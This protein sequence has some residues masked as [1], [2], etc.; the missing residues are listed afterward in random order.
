MEFK[1]IVYQPGRVARII[2]NRP[3][4]LNAQSYQMLEE[5]N[6]A[7]FT[8]EQNPVCGSI[9]LSGNGRSFCVG[10]DIGTAEDEKYKE[11][12][13]YTTNAQLDIS[14][15]FEQMRK[16]YVEYTLNW[17]NLAKPTIAMVH[18]YCIFAGWMLASAMDVIFSSEDARFLPGFTEYFSVPRD[19]NPRKAREILFEH[20][21]MTAHEAYDY[22][23]V[24]RIF[25]SGELE[26]EALAYAGRVADNYLANTSWVR[27]CK[28]SINHMEDAGGMS[29]E[30]SAAFNNFCLMALSYG[31]ALS[32]PEE[33]GFAR[34]K[35][36]KK[37]LELT[38]PWLK[39]A[40]LT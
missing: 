5:L 24:N 14:R 7:F 11:E 20:R 8:A 9:L 32:S 21:F 38:L 19:I 17:R 6:S 18:G 35:V 13:G 16:L 3:Q 33:G 25:P 29:S 31:S 26:S 30:I 27:F 4:F 34:T 28:Y 1:H 39:K 23:F 10:H 12:K 37:N 40:G 22:G 2:L 36:A 15:W